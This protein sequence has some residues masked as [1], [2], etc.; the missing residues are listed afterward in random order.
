MVGGKGA[1]KEEYREREKQRDRERKEVLIQVIFQ[2][3]MSV[4]Q[5]RI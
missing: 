2:C 4:F 1:E 3:R 5:E